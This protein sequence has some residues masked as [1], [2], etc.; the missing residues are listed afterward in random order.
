MVLYKSCIDN[1]T[2]PWLENLQLVLFQCVFYNHCINTRDSF[3][4]ASIISCHQLDI[5][6]KKILFPRF[7]FRYQSMKVLIFIL[8]C[9]V[10]NY[11][12]VLVPSSSGSGCPRGETCATRASCPYWEQARVYIEEQNFEIYFNWLH[13]N[14]KTNNYGHKQTFGKGQP[15]KKS[16]KWDFD[17]FSL[18]P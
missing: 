11:C 14:L 7:W 8:L 4:G 15:Q 1:K 12:L 10:G 18:D 17:P 9:F 13:L 6:N 16:K 2:C 3:S 5:V